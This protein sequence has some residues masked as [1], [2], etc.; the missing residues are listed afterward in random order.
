MGEERL[1][2][3]IRSRGGARLR[4]GSPL[5]R[6]AI[7]RLWTAVQAPQGRWAREILEVSGGA[8]RRYRGGK[9]AVLAISK[10]EEVWGQL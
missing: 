3:R 2:G 1:S 5:G 4:T 6:T 8:L 9:I 10:D 7:C